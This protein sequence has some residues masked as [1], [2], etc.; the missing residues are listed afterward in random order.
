MIL[1]IAFSI[2]LYSLSSIGYLLYLR[3]NRDIIQKAAFLSVIIGFLSHLI[4]FILRWSKAGFF[5]VSSLYESLIL[6]SLVAS[7]MFIYIETRYKLKIVGTFIM[8]LVL[9][10]VSIPVL[11]PIL[12]PYYN[13]HVFSSTITPLL[14]ILQSPWLLIHT[15]FCFFSYSAFVQSFGLGFMYLLQERQLKAKTANQLYFRLPPLNIL[16]IIGY[17]MMRFGF[18]FLTLGLISGS[19]WA[20][21]TWGAYWN[22]DPKEVWTLI[23]WLIY[24][25]IL[26]ARFISGF[27]GKKA[28]Y[29][30]I[31]GFVS[32][33]FTFIGVSYLLKGYHSYI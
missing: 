33:L 21:D 26:H 24:A 9:L 25:S 29:L 8:P 22:W 15:L 13:T 7:G 17:N 18:V 23:T 27:R 19:I 20:K 14:P 16:D 28:A 2:A 11:I 32:L 1:F 12:L 3:I 5:P 31:L 30:A 4:Y 10:M 6:F